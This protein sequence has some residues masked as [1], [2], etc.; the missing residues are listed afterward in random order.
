MYSVQDPKRNTHWRSVHLTK[1][2]YANSVNWTMT[3]RDVLHFPK[4][5][6]SYRHLLLMWNKLTSFLI[7]SPGGLK[8]K[9][10]IHTH[11][12]YGV[13]WII[14]IV[15]ITWIHNFLHIIIIIN[16]F[17]LNL[18]C[19]TLTLGHLSHNKQTIRLLGLLVGE[20]P[21]QEISFLITNFLINSLPINSFLTS[22]ILL[23]NTLTNSTSSHCS[24]SRT[25]LHQWTCL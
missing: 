6:Q 19:R 20:N 12:I 22:N 18:L 25:I 13:T 14:W 3:L 7:R 15:W 5:R 23:K 1:W 10:L 9:V 4:W 17:H 11:H 16:G 8:I 2:K 24:N 21:I